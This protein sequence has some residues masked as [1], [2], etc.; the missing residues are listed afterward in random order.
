MICL[1]VARPV[2]L[3]AL[4][5]A[6]TSGVQGAADPSLEAVVALCGRR[7][8]AEATDGY[9][10]VWMGWSVRPFI[11]DSVQWGRHSLGQHRRCIRRRVLRTS[12]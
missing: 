1:L 9:H 5:T 11:T 3:S 8:G 2:G 10:S 4:L 7:R 6:G 12:V